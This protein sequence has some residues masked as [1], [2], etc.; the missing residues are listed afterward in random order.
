MDTDSY[1]LLMVVEASTGYFMNQLTAPLSR[2]SH[3][4]WSFL[5]L[6]QNPS[7]LRILNSYVLHN[8][9]SSDCRVLLEPAIFYYFPRNETVADTGIHDSLIHL[10]FLYLNLTISVRT[11]I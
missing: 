2:A 6:Q 1:G 9:Y 8:T 3:C 7:Y 11:H 10:T 5:Y 4:H